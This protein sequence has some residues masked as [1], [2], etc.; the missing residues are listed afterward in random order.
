MG[1]PRRTRRRY[2]HVANAQPRQASPL[3]V[4][5]HRDERYPRPDRRRLRARFLPR[6]KRYGYGRF[7]R[8]YRNLY[9][10]VRH[11]RYPFDSPSYRLVLLYFACGALLVV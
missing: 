6:G 11:R 9:V 7:G 8:S 10:D 3:L 1:R 2:E 5:T 4:A